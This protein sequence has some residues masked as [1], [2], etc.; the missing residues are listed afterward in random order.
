MSESSGNR[1]SIDSGGKKKKETGGK[2]VG[3]CFCDVHNSIQ[4]IRVTVGEK[5]TI[6]D[7]EKWVLYVVHYCIFILLPTPFK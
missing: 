7:I 6:K 5:K 3:F 4:N 2:L 1:I